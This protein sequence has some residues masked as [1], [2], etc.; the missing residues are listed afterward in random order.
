MLIRDFERKLKDSKFLNS[1][2]GSGE[3]CNRPIYQF[4]DFLSRLGVRTE[5]EIRYNVDVRR[6]SGESGLREFHV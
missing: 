6:N 4:L 2:E 3:I 5:K 1:N